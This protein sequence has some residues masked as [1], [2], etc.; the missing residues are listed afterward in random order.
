MHALSS[1][2][3][4]HRILLILTDAL[5]SFARA[6][7]CSEIDDPGELGTFAQA[8]QEF[9]DHHH[10][11]KDEQVLLPFL[12]R[13]GFDWN[14]ELFEQVR[15]EHRRER[16]L[17]DV[18]AH[19]AQQQGRF[20]KAERLRVGATAAELAGMQR[21]LT[22]KQDIELLPEVLLLLDTS[23]LERLNE[24]LSEFDLRGS[25]STV[26]WRQRVERLALCYR[27]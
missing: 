2:H 3:Q 17:I 8:F 27:S 18:L 24:E 25:R 16:Y 21:R 5:D 13:H 1:L 20:G 26:P 15:S 6:I 12:A 9:A 7:A 4:D 22:M 23:A 14:G 10:Y 11:E 19:A